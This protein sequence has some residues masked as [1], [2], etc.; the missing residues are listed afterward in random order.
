MYV[1]TELKI[2]DKETGIFK[3]DNSFD[4]EENFM[5]IFA[6]GDITLAREVEKRDSRSRGKEEKG[7]IGKEKIK[8]R[9]KGEENC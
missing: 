3:F 7:G 6:V 5:K 4:K 8:G 2:F 1:E 9:T